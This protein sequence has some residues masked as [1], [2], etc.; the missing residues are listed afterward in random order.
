MHGR[1]G[2]HGSRLGLVVGLAAVI[3]GSAQAGTDF[4]RFDRNGIAFEYPSG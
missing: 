3:A 2:S 4:E 1:R